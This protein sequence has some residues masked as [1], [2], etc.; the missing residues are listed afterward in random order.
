M[1]TVTRSW[2]YIGRN[3]GTDRHSIY[4][5]GQFDALGARFSVHQCCQKTTAAPRQAA[6]GH[7]LDAHRIGSLD[8]LAIDVPDLRIDGL[9]LCRN[10]C[11]AG[12]VDA[13]LL[14]YSL[15]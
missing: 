1:I 11:V 7:G 3:H 4:S 14:A 6:F 9:G 2:G 13:P 8:E 12:R 10:K 15:I 5:P